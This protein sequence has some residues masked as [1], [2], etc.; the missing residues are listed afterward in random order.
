MPERND[1]TLLREYVDRHSE[2]AFADLVHQHIHLVYSVAFRYVGNSPD[3]QDITQAVFVLLAKKAASLCHR[4]TLTG[5]L[6]ETTRL[7]ASTLLRGRARQRVREHEAYM[8][9]TL[10]DP[11]A[12]GVWQQLAPVLEE[13][14]SRLNEKERTLLALRLFDNKTA[15]ET[16]ALLGIQ[17]GA[18]YKRMER[19]LEKLRLFFLR[20]GIDSSTGLIAEA[21]SANSIQTAPVALANSVVAAAMVKSVVA[22]TST[23]TLI[24]GALKIMAWSK[25]KTAIVTTVIVLLAAGAGTVVVKHIQTQRQERQRRQHLAGLTSPVIKFSPNGA[26]SVIPA[27]EVRALGQSSNTNRSYGHSTGVAYFFAIGSS[28]DAVMRELEHINAAILQDT[29]GFVRAEGRKTPTMKKNPE[30][31]RFTFTN[32]RLIHMDFILPNTNPPAPPLAET[33]Q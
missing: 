23:L 30:E 8:Q 2:P 29:P 12:G 7:T 33:G 25:T 18:A 4:A 20:R 3:A 32:D 10:N 6:Y 21:I 31:M 24:K 14:M 15:A 13:A 1:Q 26:I 27:S 22:G 5:W 17:E 19:A 11:E 16:A 9:S 28:R